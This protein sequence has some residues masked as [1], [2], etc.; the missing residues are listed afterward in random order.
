VAHPPSAPPPPGGGIDLSWLPLGAGG[1]VVPRCGRAYERLS[2]ARDR[3]P[4]QAL[5]HA[6]LEVTFAGVRHVIE[7]A[8]AWS[9]SDPG[10]GVVSTGPVG[11]RTL[12][13]LSAFR[14]EVRC[15]PDGRIPD[16][17]WAVDS[18]Q[19]LSDSDEVA[20]GMLAQVAR[21]PALTWGR[22]ELGLGEM[23][24]SN[25]LVSWLLSSCGLDAEPL[26]P[27]NGGR[28]PGWT[29]G[30]VLAGRRRPTPGAQG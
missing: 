18:P 1:W 6:A 21:V 27:P 4:R 29:A 9:T 22:D 24:N 15:W 3:R 20:A 7:M 17:A 14:Y 12:G 25:S 10:R 11:L 26:S 13:R 16:V 2:A 23:W 5:F 19:H 30:L 8:P 28:A